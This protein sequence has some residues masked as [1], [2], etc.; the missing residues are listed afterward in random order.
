MKHSAHWEI[1]ETAIT[2]D[3]GVYVEG[4]MTMQL[5][6]FRGVENRAT[7]ITVDFDSERATRTLNGSA[8]L[9]QQGIAPYRVGGFVAGGIVKQAAFAKRVLAAAFADQKPDSVWHADNCT[10]FVR[11]IDGASFP[12]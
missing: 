2:A 3:H 6:E 1:V 7:K 12:A 11:V 10:H 4:T 8:T 9:H 5:V